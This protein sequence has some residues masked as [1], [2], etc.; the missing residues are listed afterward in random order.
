MTASYTENEQTVE[1]ELGIQAVIADTASVYLL[2]LTTTDSDGNL[3][4]RFSSFSPLTI[5]VALYG[6]EGDVLW[7]MNWSH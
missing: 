1:V 6:V 4:K 3:T 5:T 7:W 2:E